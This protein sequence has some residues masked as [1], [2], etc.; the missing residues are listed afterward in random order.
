MRV[1]VHEVCKTN[2][3]CNCVWCRFVSA[4]RT[5]IHLSAVSQSSLATSCSP[6]SEMSAPLSSLAVSV[7]SVALSPS[8]EEE[9]P[10]LLS[11]TCQPRKSLSRDEQ[12]RTSVHYNHGHVA[13][14][15]PTSP[16]FTMENGDQIMGDTAAASHILA[17]LSENLLNTNNNINNCSTKKAEVTNGH[18]PMMWSPV[19]TGCS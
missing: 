10:L 2:G 11:N 13:D 3:N 1:K 7:P 5:P 12:K 16:L 4:M 17:A 18:C 6:P 15:L 8:G 14:S 19:M 9:R